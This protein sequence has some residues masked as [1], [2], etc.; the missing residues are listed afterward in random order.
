MTALTADRDCRRREG[1]E[2]KLP[3]EAGA[4]GYA[5]GLAAL[6]ASGNVVSGSTATGLQGIGRF[7]YAFNNS[8]AAA[9]AVL[10]HINTGIFNF[11]N[12]ASSPDLI[13]AAMTGQI[14]WIVDDNTVAATNGGGTRSPAGVIDGVDSLGV[15][16]RMGTQAL[17][18]P[19]GSLVAANNLS[20]LA[21]RATARANLDLSNVIMGDPVPG[22]VG[23][24][25]SKIINVPIQLKTPEGANLAIPGAIRGYLATASNGTTLTALTITGVA[26]GTNGLLFGVTD[27]NRAFLLVSNTSGQIDVNINVASGTG[28]CYLVLIEPT[29]KLVSSTAVTFT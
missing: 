28:T 27:S 14:A 23:A 26:I 5:G 17:L 24:E 25:A 8:G 21:N 10:A 22:T 29:G 16:I 20:D 13:T 4:V 6:N 11:N 1:L 2:Y 9:G 12:A 19:A 7:Q 15:W 18:T 3:A